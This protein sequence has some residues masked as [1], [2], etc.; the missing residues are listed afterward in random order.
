MSR[1]RRGPLHHE[2]Y[3]FRLIE[4]KLEYS[5][6]EYSAIAVR[7]YM[8]PSA[9]NSVPVTEWKDEQ[10]SLPFSIGS[11]LE[12]KVA[13]KQIAE[14]RLELKKLGEKRAKA[15]A[16][17]TGAFDRKH[18]LQAEALNRSI[19]VRMDAAFAYCQKNEASLFADSTTIE[20]IG[21]TIQ[22]KRCPHSVR[23]LPGWTA[24]KIL[25][26]FRKWFLGA[27]YVRVK[28][29]LNKRAILEDRE[30]RRAFQW[31]RRGVEIYQARALTITPAADKGVTVSLSR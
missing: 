23:E 3:S 7:T 17:I 20:A 4:L 14:D 22:F 19:D 9:S 28:F 13:A 21:A 12:L 1:R 6:A 25:D 15:I 26:A 11:N 18:G 24:Q 30:K 29:E 16:K 27:R 2:P 31:T 5:C 10:F 8:A